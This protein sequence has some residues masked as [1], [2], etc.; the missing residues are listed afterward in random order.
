[1][2]V[3]LTHGLGCGAKP[4][5]GRQSALENIEEIT[6]MLREN[7]KM[8]FITAGMGGGTGTGAAPV[9]AALAREMGILTV[10]IV[11]TPFGFEGKWRSATAQEG[12]EEMRHC[13]DSLLVI[14]NNHLLEV[15]RNVTARQAYT[16]ADNVLGNAAKGIAEIIT[17]PGHINV[18]FA[19]V[20]TIM[21][22]SG[23]AL[24][25]MASYS[26]DNRAL[27]AIE[28]ALASPLLNNADIHGAKGILVNITASPDSLLMSEIQTIMEYI[29]EAAGPEANIIFGDVVNEE[30][31][32]ELC[33]TVIATGLENRPYQQPR[34][35]QP[36]QQ[37]Y[38]PRMT[39]PQPT[40][41]ATRSP[42]ANGGSVHD[43]VRQHQ[44]TKRRKHLP[45]Q[46]D[47]NQRQ[48]DLFAHAQQP[49]P[50]VFEAQPAYETEPEPA[51]YGPQNGGA[52]Y[53]TVNFEHTDAHPN[54]MAQ[55]QPQPEAPANT[56]TREQPTPQPRAQNRALPQPEQPRTEVQQP[57]NREPQPRVK[58]R[59][60]EERQTTLQRHNYSLDWRNTARMQEMTN[61]PAY[62]RKGLSLEDE[63][64]NDSPRSYAR[65]S[66]DAANTRRFSLREQNSYLFDNVD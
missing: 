36:Q 47:W 35:Q 52:S 9:I 46:Q 21:K 66:V 61:Q 59:T 4:E 38:Q 55:P 56:Y 13:V 20:Q 14:D 42:L 48:P 53:G 1:L 24:M 19:D 60:A 57:A 16:L 45:H 23:S 8:V 11:T 18:D 28:E 26:G 3:N 43:L 50:P 49:Q 12:L 17:V 37:A 58:P 10:G 64:G 51:Q 44:D 15:N 5:V 29:G 33:V 34:A 54:E 2:G 22:N 32:D 7:T 62:L 39:Q 6:N 41:Q 65:L 30:L 63:A 40:V 27:T 25:G 31:G